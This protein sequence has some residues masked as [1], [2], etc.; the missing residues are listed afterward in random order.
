MDWLDI[1]RDVCFFED[2]QGAL[3][4]QRHSW[5]IRAVLFNA[6]GAQEEFQKERL[7][8]TVELTEGFCRVL[9]PDRRLSVCESMEIGLLEQ[10]FLQ[11]EVA[12]NSYTSGN[13]VLAIESGAEHPDAADIISGLKEK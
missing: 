7:W 1:P 8:R 13:R 4:S 5:S 9:Q 10:D 3:L 6:F 2:V 12:V 11:R